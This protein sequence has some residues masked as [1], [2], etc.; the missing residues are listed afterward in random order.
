MQLCST[1]LTS[2]ELF[3]SE[4]RAPADRNS[5]GTQRLLQ[6]LP[7]IQQLGLSM[8][9]MPL[10]SDDMRHVGAMQQLL[11]LEFPLSDDSFDCLDALPNSLTKLTLKYGS[12]SA[13]HPAPQ[14]QHLSRLQYLEFDN[15]S[16]TPQVLATLPQLKHHADNQQRK[17]CATSPQHELPAELHAEPKS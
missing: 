5:P 1:G 12:I 10:S 4:F 2:L 16:I 17:R 8:Y 13:D 6:Q 7:H 15:C 3:S 14:L 9:G 11:D